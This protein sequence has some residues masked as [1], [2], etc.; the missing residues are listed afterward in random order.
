MRAKKLKFLG[1]ACLP[2]L[3]GIVDAQEF[4]Q[5]SFDDIKRL[6]IEDLVNIEVTSTTR[7]TQPFFE[8]AGALDVLTG[9]EIRRSG[10]PTIQDALRLAAG[11]H[12]AQQD[13][14]TWAISTRGF[15]TATANKLQVLRDGRILYTPLYSG[16]FWDVQDYL[17]ED[18]D[19][20]EVLR[21][22]SGTLWGA[23]AVNGVI[24][25]ISKEAAQ[26]Q[27]T[28]VTAGGG[29]EETAF[30]AVRYG[31]AI[32]ENT[33]YRVYVKYNNRDGM[34]LTTGEDAGDNRNFGQAGFRLDSRP[35]ENTHFTLQ[36]DIYSGELGEYQVQDTIVGGANLLGRWTRNFDNGNKLTT[37]LYFDRSERRHFNFEE[38][39]S[40]YALN[41]QYEFQPWDRH[42]ITVGT[43]S[44]VSTDDISN[45]LPATLEFIPH[46]RNIYDA[47]LFAQDKITLVEDKL[48]LILGTKI[49]HNSFSGWEIQPS[50]RLAYLL[51]QRQTLW[52]AISRAVRTPTRLEHDLYAPGIFQDRGYGSEDV[53]AYEL[54]YRVQPSTRTA[55]EVAT[56]INDYENLR[57]VEPSPGGG[58]L[59]NEM[60]GRTYGAELTFRVQPT[61]W[62]N[63]KASY[64]HME[65]ELTPRAWSRDAAARIREGND[66]ENMARVHSSI[67]LPQNVTFDAV[68]RYVDSLPAPAIPAYLELDLRLAWKPTK[69]S[70]IAIVGRN[71]L[72]ESHPEFGARTLTARE[73]ERSAYVK[74]TLNF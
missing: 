38:D 70:E 7:H 15:N 26:T 11:V 68:V 51:S 42:E 28:L 35:Q 27:G 29:F 34:Q 37:Q 41:L 8:T 73:V 20:I 71:L 47:S 18:L 49:L 10:A 46:K 53:I 17:L 69:N 6:T 16:V 12:V 23:N 64:T 57:T 58:L 3:A 39:R 14:K 72:D 2:I 45:P 66:P 36:G 55:F 25:I 31:G 74:L 62:W 43:D 50:A 30:G 60:D 54:G 44:W 9:E 52:G 21:G 19:R 65:K 59:R 63:I 67:D 5:R 13:G 56:F 61:D 24:N 4:A 48:G 33:H 22:P 1:A 32:N 40:T